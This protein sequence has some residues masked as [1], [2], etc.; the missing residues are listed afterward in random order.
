MHKIVPIFFL[1]L[2]V[3]HVSL[4][5]KA[6]D[7]QTWEEGNT[8]LMTLYKEQ[9]FMKAAG[10]GK[11][12]VQEAR[13][14]ADS[15]ERNRE[16]VITSLGNLAMIYTHLGKYPE[17]EEL[18]WEELTLRQMVY[19][20]RGLEVAVGWQHLALI[21][22]MAQVPEDAETCLLTSLAIV[23][24]HFGI[25]SQEVLA[26]YKRL[27]KFYKITKNGMKEKEITEI[28]EKIKKVNG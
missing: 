16:K 15:D 1:V 24:E 25:E 17:A 18:A 26:S 19:G 12:L 7:S 6:E 27:L 23:E 13:R 28:V 8:N 5:L 10:L 21:Y 3:I 4:P 22:T 14:L 11:S 20:K 9:K 2:V